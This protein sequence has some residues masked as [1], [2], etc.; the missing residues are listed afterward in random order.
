MN[1]DIETAAPL[2]RP[3]NPNLTLKRLFLFA[4]RLR[5]ND[6]IGAV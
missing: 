4:A 2:M 1:D 3:G 6:D 5:I